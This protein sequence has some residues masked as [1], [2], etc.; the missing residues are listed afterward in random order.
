MDEELR[1]AFISVVQQL[2]THSIRR[3]NNEA[4]EARDAPEREKQAETRE[5]L[6]AVRKAPGSGS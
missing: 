5:T 3:R 4:Q 1:D 2:D 6:R